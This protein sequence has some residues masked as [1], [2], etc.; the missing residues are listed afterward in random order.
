MKLVFFKPSGDDYIASSIPST[1]VI[2]AGDMEE[3]FIVDIVDDEVYEVPELFQIT[4]RFQ[5]S[6]TPDAT[7]GVTINDDDGERL[8]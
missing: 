6:T 2:T 8:L 4:A 1:I 7:V 3:C 5:D